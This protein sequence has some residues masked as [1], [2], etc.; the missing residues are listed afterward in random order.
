MV[1]MNWVNDAFSASLKDSALRSQ[2]DG[3]SGAFDLFLAKQFDRSSEAETA[4]RSLAATQYA[5][6]E[7]AEASARKQLEIHEQIEDNRTKRAAVVHSAIK[8]SEAL[9]QET[10]SSDL[11]SATPGRLVRLWGHAKKLQDLISSLAIDDPVTIRSVMESSRTIEQRLIDVG[12]GAPGNVAQAIESQVAVTSELIDEITKTCKLIVML[13][14]FPEF[15]GRMSSESTANFLAAKADGARQL[16][17]YLGKIATLIA[18]AIEAA[19]I[20]QDEVGSPVFSDMFSI[21]DGSG[22]LEV[23][24]GVGVAAFRHDLADGPHQRVLRMAVDPEA[25]EVS[26]LQKETSKAVRAWRDLFN[27]EREKQV[28]LLETFKDYP[29]KAADRI[30]RRPVEFTDWTVVEVLTPKPFW[31]SSDDNNPV[32]WSALIAMFLIGF[33]V[34][35][36]AV[37]VTDDVGLSL[38]SWLASAVG[39]F[40]VITD[41]FRKHAGRK[42]VKIGREAL[43]NLRL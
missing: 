20:R 25:T 14:Y 18:P 26:R 23:I 5:L 37:I 10:E 39:G 9:R 8:F 6:Q 1:V 35:W 33:P 11:A 27:A 28:E 42:A 32:A 38:L 24:Q 36:I 12:V 43:D 21:H 2:L 31:T 41:M 15:G 40:F 3:K 16:P 29:D 13:E 7:F 19:L 22:Q 34:A 30:G 4:A 17:I